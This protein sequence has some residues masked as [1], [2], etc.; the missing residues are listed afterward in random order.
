MKPTCLQAESLL[1][2]RAAGLSAAESLR[3]EAH[4]AGCTACRETASMLSELRALHLTGQSQLDPGSRQR[5]IQAALDEGCAS[6]PVA[7]REAERR[8]AVA[9]AGWRSPRLG[10][11][12]TLAACVALG[13]TWLLARR[14]PERADRVLSGELIVGGAARTDGASLPPSA[15]FEATRES[16]VTLGHATVQLSGGT[17]VGWSAADHAL[18]LSEGTVLVDV[19]ATKHQP[20]DVITPRFRVHVLGTLFRVTLDS[21]EVLRG[22]VRVEGAPGTPPQVLDATQ[23]PR[24]DLPPQP[25]P[26]EPGAPH[27]TDADASRSHGSAPAREGRGAGEGEHSAEQALQVKTLGVARE[28]PAR[29]QAPQPS[30]AAAPNATRWPRGR[31]SPSSDEKDTPRVG[32]EREGLAGRNVRS[33]RGDAAASLRGEGDE[34][35]AVSALADARAQL[36]AGRVAEARR[37]LAGLRA[38]KLSQAQRAEMAS[39]EAECHVVS[40]NYAA[41]QRA[42]LAVSE[43]FPRLSAAETALFAA[44]RIAAEHGPASEARALLTRYL[45][46][47]PKGSF[48]AEATKRLRA[49]SESGSP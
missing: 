33:S 25:K 19:D 31:V 3:V 12:M 7:D 45:A 30:A 6:V 13:G 49:L 28:R 5:A 44:A 26:P 46:R 4:L 38:V 21:V 42:F 2:R 39:L 17:R 29:V 34:A 27:G 15:A 18:A 1:Q 16:R 22:R 10:V 24:F 14:E 32:P 36:A 35:A 20:F 8:V 9:P 41:A 47:H 48:V 11:V 40:G 37:G 23:H 43:R